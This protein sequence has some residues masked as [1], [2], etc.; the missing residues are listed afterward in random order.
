MNRKKPIAPWSCLVLSN[1]KATMPIVSLIRNEPRRK[2]ARKALESGGY[3]ET[4]GLFDSA[5]TDIL[6]DLRHLCDVE[7]WDFEHLA[8]LSHGHWTEEDGG[9]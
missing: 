3:I 8:N 2:R 9:R 5:V 4:A 7:G 6:T 1:G